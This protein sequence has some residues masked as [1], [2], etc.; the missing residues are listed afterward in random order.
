M[1][2][3]PTSEE[4]CSREMSAW[5]PSILTGSFLRSTCCLPRS[6]RSSGTG[7]WRRSPVSS[8]RVTTRGTVRQCHQP[9]PSGVDV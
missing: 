6:W 5:R 2:S 1:V 3:V 4:M 9:R 7:F 8:S